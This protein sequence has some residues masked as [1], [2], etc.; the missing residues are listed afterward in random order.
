M[1]G[2]RLR[3][4]DECV[5]VLYDDV[6]LLSCRSGGSDG[7]AP[8]I[9]PLCTPAGRLLSL[10][11]PYDHPWHHGLFFAWPNVSGYNFLET[12]ERFAGRRGTVEQVAWCRREVVDGVA[13]ISTRNR[14][15]PEGAIL[16]IIVEERDVSVQ[17]PIGNRYS[18][19]IE[20][21]IHVDPGTD[22]PEVTL[23]SF[24]PYHGLSF[25]PQR[26]LDRARLVNSEGGKGVRGTLGVSARWCA[27][28][29]QL[30]SPPGWGGVAILDHP[31]NPRHP[32]PFF[33]M[34]VPEKP[35]AFIGAAPCFEEPLAIVKGE[36]VGWKY[37]LVVFDGVLSSDTLDVEWEMFRHEKPRV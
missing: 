27:L 26:S 37:R 9:H 21:A 15:L 36:P 14:W 30:D 31:E 12:S 18:I 25:R 3:S 24:P 2:I 5:D 19:D 28:M 20:V 33:T 10:D 11:Q 8:H 34:A 7:G 32:T 17:A 35:F 22:E 4:T 13:R 6:R 1:S 16:P 29:G 23:A